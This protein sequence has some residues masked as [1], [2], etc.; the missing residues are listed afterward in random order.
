M[1]IDKHFV[2]QCVQKVTVHLSLSALF[3]GAQLLFERTVLPMQATH[4]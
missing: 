1:F 4:A 2:V 3:A